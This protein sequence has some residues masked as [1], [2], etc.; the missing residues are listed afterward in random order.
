ML[1]PTSKQYR[2]VT[3]K[4][5]R[6]HLTYLTTSSDDTSRV[7]MVKL[8]NLAILHGLSTYSPFGIGSLWKISLE[9]AGLSS[10]SPSS[11]ESQNTFKEIIIES[12]IPNPGL[13]K[14]FN[15]PSL[16]AHVLFASVGE[17][18]LHPRSVNA[19]GSQ[20]EAILVERA[21]HGSLRRV[22]RDDGSLDSVYPRRRPRRL[23]GP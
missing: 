2:V 22:V 7:G 4:G 23:A 1:A 11:L 8:N 12:S 15:N 14:S 6:T 19:I 5:R 16:M 9:T 20:Q 18:F 10:L 21:L 17:Q 13:T 3:K